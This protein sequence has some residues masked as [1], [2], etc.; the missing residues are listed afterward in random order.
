MA[1]FQ[2]SADFILHFV[3][4]GFFFGFGAFYLLT[5]VA[6]DIAF[7]KFGLPYA[8]L[9]RLSMVVL[10][11]VSVAALGIVLLTWDIRNDDH[12]ISAASLEI[13]AFICFV[14]VYASFFWEFR[15]FE[16]ILKVQSADE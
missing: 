7:P 12:V 15:G 2:V 6:A 11:V 3:G 9:F 14:S 5:V 1:A 16:L 13:V 4:A 8:R 10:M